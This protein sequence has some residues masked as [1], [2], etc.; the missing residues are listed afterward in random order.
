MTSRNEKD[1][2]RELRRMDFGEQRG[3]RVSLL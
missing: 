2:E 1:E 3:E